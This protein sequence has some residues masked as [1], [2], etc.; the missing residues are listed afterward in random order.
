MGN[1][2]SLIGGE[3]WGAGYG[4]GVVLTYSFP[5]VPGSFFI[6]PYGE[7]EQS[8]ML[9][10]T[11]TERAGVRSALAAWSALANVSFSEVAD[12]S[13]LV[14]DLRLAVTTVNS[15]GENGHAYLPS[16]NPDA[17]DVW[18]SESNWHVNR[19]SAVQ[20][21]SYDYV[22]LIHE[23]GHALG[24]KH[25]FEAPQTI[26]P[27]FDNYSF[28]VMSYSAHSGANNSANFYPTTPMWYD[29]L[30]IQQLYGARPHN[31]GNTTYTYSTSRHYWQTID[32]SGGIDT[33][34]VSGK[35]RATIDLNIGHWSKIGL[36]ITFGDGSKQSDTVMT[37]PRSFIEN[38][39]GGRGNDRLTG[40]ALTN[41]LNGGKG[42]DV[43]NGLGGNDSLKAGAGKDTFSFTGNFGTDTVV[44]F[45]RTDDLIAVSHALFPNFRALKPALSVDASL[46]VVITVGASSVILD[47]I[48]KIGALHANDFL[49]V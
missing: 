23:I 39:I 31:A 33:I 20:P 21:G 3:K 47:T 45:S 25:P 10:L 13:V 11:S 4:S 9:S 14:G 7:G 38:A 26:D 40:N 15:G 22:T 48:H 46:H 35:G 29:I 49:F 32:D 44:D 1:A 16:N 28:T 17:G 30:A 43:L 24:L 36:P 19:G 5:V 41:S 18:L 6:V 42:D 8:S 34:A 2:A 27:A 12:N 37:G